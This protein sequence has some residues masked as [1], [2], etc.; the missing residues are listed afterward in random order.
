VYVGGGITPDEKIETPHSNHF[1]DVLM[2]HYVFFN[3]ARHY[4]ASRSVGRDF[5]VDD[6]VM[7]DFRQ[8]LTSSQI[9]FSDPDLRGVSDWIKA[10]IKAEIFTSQFGQTE[11]LKVRAEW[12]PMIQKALTYMPQAQALE[13]NVRKVLA[14]K[15]QALPAPRP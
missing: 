4:L 3:F 11:G 12:D 5:Q 13:D 1:Q 6:A 2:Q 9:S 10:N 15:A 8:F 7:T 14:A